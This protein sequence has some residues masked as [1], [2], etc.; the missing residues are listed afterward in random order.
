[1]GRRH[2]HRSH[3]RGSRRNTTAYIA[4]NT[5]LCKACW[6]CVD[7]CPKGVMGKMDFFFHRHARIVN[8]GDCIGCRACEKACP[9]GAIVALKRTEDPFKE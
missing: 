9:E 7:A 3:R 5:K 2:R 6:K 1:M 4:I 8:P